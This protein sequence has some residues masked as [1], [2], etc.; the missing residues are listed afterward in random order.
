VAGNIGRAS[1]GTAPPAP[2]LEY[3]D[4]LR[5][6]A[7]LWVVLHHTIEVA[8]PRRLLG[9]PAVGPVV[10]SLSYG[11][12][13]VMIFLMLSGFVLYYP[14]V[15]RDPA[16]PRLTTSVGT[17]LRR[18]YTRIAPPYLWVMGIC[19]VLVAIPVFQ[20][21][22]WIPLSD[23]TWPIVGSH[24]VF[25]HNL[26][27]DYATRIDYP[28]WSIG[29]EF[30][31]YLLFPLMVW[32]FLKMGG[33]VAVL[34]SLTLAAVVFASYKH[35][36]SGIGFAL[37]N[38]PLAYLGIFALGMLAASITVR[39]VKLAPKWLWI[40]LAVLGLGLVRFGSGNGFVHDVSTAAA[41][42][43]ILMLCVDASAATCRTL[44]AR[45]LVGLGFFSYSLYLVHAPVLHI[46]DVALDNLHVRPDVQFV[47]LVVVGLPVI[48]AASYGVH[49][50]FERPFMRTRRAPAAPRVAPVGALS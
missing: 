37:R 19:L 4:G 27:P 38:G 11:Q 45:Y 49:L 47:L 5:A 33:R 14:C 32:A 35:L 40:T 48:L 2:R 24:L 21:V 17:F 34:A 3:I 28:M 8:E 13:P 26:F 50:A 36:P 9:L 23:M 44:S 41:G 30:Q 43:A 18:R 42:F 10:Q 39:G 16:R 12:F 1:A 20:S 31:L 29:L 25:A 7:A 22:A 46:M 6:I 15:R